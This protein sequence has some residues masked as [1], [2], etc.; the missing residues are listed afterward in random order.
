MAKWQTPSLQRSKKFRRYDG[1][2][3]SNPSLETITNNNMTK[4]I[5]IGDLPSN[6]PVLKPIEF[7]HAIAMDSK[8]PAA[9]VSGVPVTIRE[10]NGAPSTYKY[11]ELICEE[12]LPGIDIMF[13]YYNPKQRSQGVLFFGKFNDGVVE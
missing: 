8:S 9:T 13:A 2:E 6:G 7:T 1:T 10:S 11:I 12:Y 4:I 5:K 3:G